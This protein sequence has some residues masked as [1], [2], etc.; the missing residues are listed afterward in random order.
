MHIDVAD[1]LD[2]DVDPCLRLEFR[3]LVLD[4]LGVGDILHKDV[5]CSGVRRRP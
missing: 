4:E 5:H 2:V 1:G 3:E